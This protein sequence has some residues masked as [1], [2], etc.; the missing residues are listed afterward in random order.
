MIHVIRH[1]RML[2]AKAFD[3]VDMIMRPGIPC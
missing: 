1:L 3:S 2:K